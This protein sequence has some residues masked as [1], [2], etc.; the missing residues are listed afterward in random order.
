MKELFTQF[1][2]E[3]NREKSNKASSYIRAIDLLCP[4]LAKKSKEFGIYADIWAIDSVEIISAL[5]DYVLV[6]QRRYKKGEGIFI[7]YEKNTSYW[8]GGFCSAALAL[9]REFLIIAPYEKQLWQIVDETNDPEVVKSQLSTQKLKNGEKLISGDVDYTSKEGKEAI[10]EVKARVNQDFFRK[11]VLANF[12]QQCA[13]TGLNIPEVLR[14]S[15]IIPWSKDKKNRLNPANGISLSATYDAAFDRH[16][17]T[18]DEDLRMVLSKSLKA[19]YTNQ[20]FQEQFQAYEGRQ[21]SSAKRFPLSQ[22]FLDK[23]RKSFINS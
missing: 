10:L 9:Y 17:I 15:H 2:Y 7:G 6:E 20:A 21:L 16:L 4:I 8:G 19:Y 23:H 22:I 12:G 11:M 1:I 14:A 5:Y 3:N 18:F 13:L